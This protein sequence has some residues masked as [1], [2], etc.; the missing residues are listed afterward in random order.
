[1]SEVLGGGFA[2]LVIATT[3][4]DVDELTRAQTVERAFERSWAVILA[5]FAIDL[6]A[7][8]ALNVLQAGDVLFT[9]LSYAV[10]VMTALLMFAPVDATISADP[11]WWLLPSAFSRSIIAAFRAAVFPRVLI[12]LAL[13]IAQAWLQLALQSLM[14]GL[15]V[16]QPALW[17]SGISIALILP[18]AQTFATFAYLDAIAYEPKRSCSE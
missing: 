6:F 8:I 4:A 7:S 9:L 17:A 15:H 13:E 2:A 10:L 14:T 3:F 16:G 12:L 5:G 11:W 18:L 1:V